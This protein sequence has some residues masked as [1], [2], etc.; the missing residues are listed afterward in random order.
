MLGVFYYVNFV[1]FVWA[2]IFE[3]SATLLRGSLSRTSVSLPCVV[4]LLVC[5]MGCLTCTGA[6][7]LNVQAV[8]HEV[9]GVISTFVCR[10]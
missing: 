8:P 9:L 10:G 2:Y 7:P 6:G 4:V 5:T 1:S 3:A